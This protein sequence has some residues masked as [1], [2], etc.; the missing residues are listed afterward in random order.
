MEFKLEDLSVYVRLIEHSR[1]TCS[2]A[3]L[4]KGVFCHKPFRDTNE[5][6]EK[7]KN[8]GAV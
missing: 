6:S 7:W 2:Y 1:G 5:V 4:L 8:V 3:T